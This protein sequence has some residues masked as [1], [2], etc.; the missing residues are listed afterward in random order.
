MGKA[1]TR[2][3]DFDGN[4]LPILRL[5]PQEIGGIYPGQNEDRSLVRLQDIPP[6]LG[7][8]LIAVEDRYF[9]EHHGISPRA[10]GRAAIANIRSGGVV[11]GGSTLTQQLVKNFYLNRS[12]SFSRKLIEAIMSLQLEFH[13]SKAEILETYINEVYLGQAGSRA[14]HG[15]ALGSQYYFRQPLNELKLHQIALLVGEV[16]GASYY[17]PWKRPERA[18]ERRDLVLHIM[19]KSELISDQELQQAQQQPLDVVDKPGNSLYQYPA[20]IDLV[21]RQLKTNYKEEDLRNEGLRIFTTLSPTI[22]RSA[23]VALTKRL[24]KIEKSFSVEDNA[25]QGAVVVTDVGSGEVLALVGDRNS[26]YLGF[27]RALSAKRSIGSL[28]KP[29]VYLTALSQPEKY[30]LVTKIDDSPITI[31]GDNGDLWEPQNFSRQSHGEVP[32]LQALALSYNQAT[33]RLGMH[34][35]V[36]A[37]IQTMNDLGID[38]NIPPLPSLFLGAI[39]LTP[40][41]V[42]AMYQT[43]ASEGVY[44]PHRAIRSV[45]DATGVPLSRYPLDSQL[46]FSPEAVSVLNFAL[47]TTMR[48]GTGR[49]AYQQLP[50]DL[51]VAGKTGTSNE[52]RD[53]WFAGFSS[54]HLAVV[55]VGRDDN[56]PT[57]LTGATGALKVWADLLTV[58]PTRSITPLQAPNVSYYRVNLQEGTLLKDSCDEG[59]V[60][61]F[62]NGSEPKDYGSC[63]G[64]FSR[65]TPLF[66]E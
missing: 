45:L 19:N 18:K 21:K 53:S 12:Q 11:Q 57:P 4:P 64:F 51:A 49:T 59:V 40:F 29:A 26:G 1:I 14:I 7:Q 37:V 46:R 16:K 24:E 61:P 47:Q 66:V 3:D 62:I 28:A 23:Q 54:D 15:F 10:I 8:A 38:E 36:D 50:N 20:F 31:A 48:S 6:I 52:Q 63:G 17:N 65:E 35:G 58:I 9:L 41:Q 55:W 39:D 34:L 27:N 32:L 44:A 5:E 2:L 43:I 30:S 22:Q 25:L 60:V 13:Y 42:S 33:T 56:G